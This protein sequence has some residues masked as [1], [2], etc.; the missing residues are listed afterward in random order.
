MLCTHCGLSVNGGTAVWNDE[1]DRDPFCS[2]ECI[3]AERIYRELE[4]NPRGKK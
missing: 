2:E 1:P 4:E 3:E